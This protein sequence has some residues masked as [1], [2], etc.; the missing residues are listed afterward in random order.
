MYDSRM[1][2]EH[3]ID[4]RVAFEIE[5]FVDGR[6]Y[7][8]DFIIENGKVQLIRIAK[9]LLAKNATFGST[10]AYI[11]PARLPEEVSEA[12]LCETLL[13]GA[14]AL[15]FDRALCM[16]DFIV[17]H[18]EIVLLEMTP[19]PG[20]DCL[21]PLVR[22]SLGIDMFKL[23]FDFAEGKPVVLPKKSATA[24]ALVGLRL[25]ADR[26]GM[27]TAMET[28]RIEKDAR[29]REVYLKRS[30]GHTVVLPPDDYDSRILGH[31]LFAPTSLHNIEKECRELVSML[32]IQMEADHDQKFHG[33]I[34]AHSRIAASANTGS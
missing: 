6:E 1:V 19:R 11:V 12:Q 23:T 24:S 22:Q 20:G 8:A 17:N 4:T 7:S 9:K 31:I 29:V 21:P 3:L 15:A 2:G 34:D 14:Q 27:I 5:E 25:F 13:H 28:D 30:I 10:L 16:V 33:G 32:E 18:D 26:P